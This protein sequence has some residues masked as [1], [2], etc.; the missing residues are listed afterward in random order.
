ML[1]ICIYIFNS[2]YWL[3]FFGG[4]QWE[5]S[6]INLKV[7]SVQNQIIDLVNTLVKILHKS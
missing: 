1:Y 6:V 7:T 5:M 2:S 4:G 3:F